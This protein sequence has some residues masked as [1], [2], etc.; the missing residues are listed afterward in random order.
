MPRNG[1]GVYTKAAGTTAV[2]NTTIESAKYNSAIDDIAA[3]LNAARPITAGGTGATSAA[4]ARTGLGFAATAGNFDKKGADVASAS[5]LTLG[6]DGNYF[7]I[8]GTTT[9]TA[10]ATKGVGAAVRLHFDGALTLTHHSTDLVLPNGANILTAAGDEAEFVEYATGDWRLTNYLKASGVP[11]GLSTGAG[12][13]SA[14]DYF[15][16]RAASTTVIPYDNTIPQITEGDALMAV[17]ITPTSATTKLRV[18]VLVCGTADDLRNV[19]AALFVNG[20]TNAVA[21]AIATTGGANHF[22]NLKISYEYTP[23]VTTL[24]TF[25]VRVGPAAGGATFYVNG[26]SGGDLFG[27]SSLRSS[28][29]VEEVVG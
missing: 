16:A 6:D 24:Q 7:D 27:G 18:S 4:A 2:A 5:T 22:V 1:S 20:G 8:T 21:T 28:L 25:N 29:I 14:A 13:K 23:G 11:L 3:D 26:A 12:L 19:I 17:T 9:I 10:I 15:T